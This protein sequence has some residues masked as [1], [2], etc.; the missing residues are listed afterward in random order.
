M[1]SFGERVAGHL[2]VGLLEQMRFE[3]SVPAADNA[4]EI[5]LFSY[6]GV[7]VPARNNNST[8]KGP[9]FESGFLQRGVRSERDLGEGG[10][11]DE[12]AARHLGTSW[13]PVKASPGAMPYPTAPYATNAPL[14]GTGSFIF[15][16]FHWQLTA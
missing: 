3:R 14:A 4:F 12:T 8:E 9:E 16:I 11:A 15:A 10:F 5:A 13:P 6:S 7:P 2:A 1:A